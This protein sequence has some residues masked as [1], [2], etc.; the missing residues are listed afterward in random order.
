[1]PPG[2][3]GRTVLNNDGIA[4]FFF[5]FGGIDHDKF[6]GL[7]IAAAGRKS[8]G[9]NDFQKVLTRNLLFRNKCAAAFSLI[10]NFKKV[11][12]QLRNYLK[13]IVFPTRFPADGKI[14]SADIL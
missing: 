2:G 8:A 9:F 10:H 5:G 6:P 7:G 11:H 1:M 13:M 4:E 14:F 12:Y 3:A